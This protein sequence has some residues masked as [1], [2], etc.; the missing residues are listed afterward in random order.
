[1]SRGVSKRFHPLFSSARPLKGVL[2]SRIMFVSVLIPSFNYASVI[3]EAIESV[4]AQ[5]YSNFELIIADDGSQDG[6]WEVLQ[7]YAARYP[8]K[9]KVTRHDGGRNAGIEATYKL[10][11]SLA[12]GEL[13]AFLEA[14][15]LWMPDYLEKKTVF[16]GKFPQAGVVTSGYDLMGHPSGCCYWQIYQLTNRLSQRARKPQNIFSLYLLRNPAASFSHFMIR[17]ELFSRIP[18]QQDREIFFDWWVLAHAAAFSDFVYV[19]ER[20]S[21]WRIHTASANFG[22]ITYARM[23]RLK[24]F[25]T[26]LYASLETLEL[27]DGQRKILDKRR[28]RMFDYLG[29]F[30][31]RGLKVLA[32]EPYYGSRFLCHIGLSHLLMGGTQ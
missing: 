11:A 18:Q 7:S 19:P 1:M 10:A 8:G 13:L 27:P 4:L 32:R 16:F 15:D 22:P 17:A 25:M 24:T 3:G 5:T 20:L 29:F 21:R 23:L 28:S 30:E 31:G 6:S 2:F 26:H 9:I 14:D 12:K